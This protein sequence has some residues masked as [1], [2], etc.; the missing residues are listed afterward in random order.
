MS[1][2]RKL[3]PPPFKTKTR[4]SSFLNKIEELE[5]DNLSSNGRG[6]ARLNG[7]VVFISG[8]L[9]REIVKARITRVKKDFMEA[10]LIQVLQSNPHRIDPP[11]SRFGRCGGCQMQHLAYPQQLEFKKQRVIEA[12]ARQ[13]GIVLGG[14]EIIASE[15]FAYRNRVRFHRKK[16]SS[17]LGFRQAGSHEI[18]LIDQC[19]VLVPSINQW[20]ESTHSLPNS[21]SIP[22]FSEGSDGASCHSDDDVFS[23]TLNGKKVFLSNQVFFQSNL[24]LLP[25]LIDH[26]LDQTIPGLVMDLFAGIGL[27]SVFLQDQCQKVIAVEMNE[28]C[29][30]IADKHLGHNVERYYAPVEEWIKQN[31]TTVLDTVIIDPPREGVDADALESIKRLNCKRLIYVSCN[32]ITQARDLKILKETFKINTATLFDMFPQTHHIETVVTMDKK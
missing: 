5:I 13:G 7:K 23:I 22:V 6:V 3:S 10:D 14:L 11:C 2:R 30:K 25:K 4:T 29:Q 32:P 28:S 31:Q 19:P 21:E 26:V 1:R 8:A 27:F 12:F 18:E 24:S 20:L 9:P 17:M 16:N 15:P